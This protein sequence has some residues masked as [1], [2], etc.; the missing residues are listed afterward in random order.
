MW[1]APLRMEEAASALSSYLLPGLLLLL[2]SSWLGRCMEEAVVVGEGQQGW[3]SHWAQSRVMAE[4]RRGNNLVKILKEKQELRR[5]KC[6]NEQPGNSH[7]QSRRKKVILVY[8]SLKK[9]MYK[10]MVSKSFWRG[11][12]SCAS[13]LEIPAQGVLSHSLCSGHP[14]L[15]TPD[16][17]S[18]SHH[19]SLTSRARHVSL[20][21]M[22][23]RDLSHWLCLAKLSNPPT[24]SSVCLPAPQVA[25]TG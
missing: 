2:S 23:K 3:T 15:N 21:A 5:G 7:P 6:E 19:I 17:A 16:Q 4:G 22:D 20:S 12:T 8:E 25:A 14:K 18:A 10:A 9:G 13:T 11:T 24:D 1:A